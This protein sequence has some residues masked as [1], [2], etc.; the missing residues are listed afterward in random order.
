MTTLYVCVHVNM[1]YNTCVNT[2]FIAWRCSTAF[3]LCSDEAHQATVDV[4][5]ASAGRAM[6]HA[7]WVTVSLSPTS[8]PSPS[9]S[10]LTPSPLTT[11]SSPP[12][13]PCLSTSYP[14][15]LSTVHPHHLSTPHPFIPP[16]LSPQAPV[17][18]TLLLETFAVL[19]TFLPVPWERR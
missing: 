11:L 14:T 18:R 1:V 8:H 3:L 12:L 7:R 4:S 17:W 6:G 16:S 5:C 15:H 19:V 9:P 2:T 13:T 10:P